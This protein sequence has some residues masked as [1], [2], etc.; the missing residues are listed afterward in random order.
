MSLA[1]HKTPEKLEMNYVPHLGQME[2]IEAINK[3]FLSEEPAAIIE[4]IASRGWGKTLFS[5][6]QVLMPYLQFT[7]DLKVMWV[8]PTYSTAMS[9]IDDVFRGVDERTGKRWI[10]EFD[11]KGNRVWEFKST[12]SGPQLTIWNGSTVSFKSADAPDSI[13]SRGYNLIIIDEAALIEEHVFTQQILGTARKQGIKIFIISSPRGK[14][15]WTYKYFLKGQDKSNKQYISFQQPYTKNPHFNPVLSKLIKDLPEWLYRQE[16]LAEFI[17]DGDSVIRGL[18]HIIQGMEIDFESTQQ[19]WDTDITDITIKSFQGDTHRRAKERKFI[20]AMDLAKSV[21]FTVLM[22]MDCEN[23][24]VV[25]YK[26][27]NKTDY[28]EILELATQVCKRYNDAELIFDA[29]GVGAGLGDVLENYD[30]TSVPFVFTNDSKVDIINK[31]ILSIEHRE[32]MIPNIVTIKNELS[33]YTYTLTRTGKISYNAPS[34]FHDDIVVTLAMANFYRK[35]NAGLDEVTSIDN[36][37]DHNSGR[38]GRRNFRDE[39]YDDN[40]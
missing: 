20:V 2:V 33:A 15:H 34:G 9:P 39:M 3:N 35:D 18:E 17:D 28:R 30:V 16:Y 40:D 10:P 4:V 5:V 8:A 23:G 13:V 19:E 29:T 7:E 31:L 1:F 11:D 38:G 36:L 26:R 21:D 32:I 12:M 22:A 27:L 6:M 24:Q 14:K 37:I 25:Y